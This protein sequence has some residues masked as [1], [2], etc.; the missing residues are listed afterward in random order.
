M[1]KHLSVQGAEA[2]RHRWSNISWEERSQCWGG[3]GLA[4][5]SGPF[6][7]GILVRE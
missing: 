3:V 1:V 4:E 2:F 6:L 7:Y 5:E